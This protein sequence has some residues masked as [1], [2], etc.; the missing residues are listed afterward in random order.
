MK[1][2][3]GICAWLL[4]LLMAFPAL[5]QTNT[6]KWTNPSDNST[7]TLALPST[8]VFTGPAT[9]T[10]QTVTPDGTKSVAPNGASLTTG[11]GVWSWNRE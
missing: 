2:Q 4:V 11:A 7:T 5:A 8:W 3:L 6:Y 10:S 1:R 9:G